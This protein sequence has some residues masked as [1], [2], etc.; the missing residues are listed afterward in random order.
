MLPILL[1][2]SEVFVTTQEAMI[3]GPVAVSLSNLRTEILTPSPQ[4]TA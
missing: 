1:G 3:C 2:L 4:A